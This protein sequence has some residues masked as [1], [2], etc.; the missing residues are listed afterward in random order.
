ML[1]FAEVEMPKLWAELPAP[2]ASR[3]SGLGVAMPFELWNWEADLDTPPGALGQWRNFDVA[4]ELSR[5]FA[6]WPVRLCNDATSAC[7]AELTFGAGAT[8]RDFA[9]FY[10]GTFIGGGL[11]LNG[12]LFPRRP[13]NARALG[14]W[15]LPRPGPQLK[16]STRHR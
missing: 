1:A 2:H 10:V 3:I 12:R 5:R 16:G 15:R 4:A 13:G 14:A 6:P 9:Y 7:A 11:L 8:Y